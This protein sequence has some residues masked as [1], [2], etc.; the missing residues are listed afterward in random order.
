MTVLSIEEYKEK[1]DLID[2]VMYSDQME[3]YFKERKA[4]VVYLNLGVNSDSKLT[5]AVPEEEKYT[6]LCEKVD[7]STMHDILVESRVLKTP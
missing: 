5:T 3:T 2:E 4:S 1:Y 6:G 7:K